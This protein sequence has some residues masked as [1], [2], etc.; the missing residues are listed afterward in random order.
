MPPLIRALLETFLDDAG[1]WEV[2]VDPDGS[3]WEDGE[4]LRD[5]AMI[6]QAAVQV[7]LA[8]EALTGERS[9]LGRKVMERLAHDA[10]IELPKGVYQKRRRVLHDTITP[11]LLRDALKRARRMTWHSA[12]AARNTAVRSHVS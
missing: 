3:V 9:R 2:R 6:A 4:R 7:D 11:E 1:V 10:G 5:P 8:L 12:R